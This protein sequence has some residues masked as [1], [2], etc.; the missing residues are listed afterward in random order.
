MF[1]KTS[2]AA[3][4]HRARSKR[5]RFLHKEEFFAEGDDDT[6]GRP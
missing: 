6:D 2:K 3:L 4:A 1:D 5:E